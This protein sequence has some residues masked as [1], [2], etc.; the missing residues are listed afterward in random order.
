MILPTFSEGQILAELVED[1]KQIK[2]HAKKKADAYLYKARKCGRFIRETDYD[3]LLV[4]TS[5][6]NVWDL[7]IEYDQTKRIPWSFRA[8]C[9]VESDKKTKDYYLVRGVNSDN[10]YFV[11]VTSHALKRYKERNF[12]DRFHL[13]L[14]TY[15]C[16]AF[17]HRETAVCMR[18]VDLKFSQLLHNMNDVDDI[19][20]MSY[21]V[22]TDRGV[23]FAS[24]TSL[25]NYVFK[26]YISTMMGL[27]EV[28]KFNNKKNTKWKKEGEL[29]HNMIIVHQYYNKFL[30]D[31]KV[32]DDM[33]YSVIGR[34]QEMVLNK[35]IDVYLLNN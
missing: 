30:Y 32:L 10:P 6:N 33:L 35:N 7:E 3:S 18:F 17:E 11:K 14:S 25:G 27:A 5:S 16:M 9:I 15:A 4:K 31:K 21:I 8:C 34:D 24:R 23:Y 28:L 1:Y 19:S 22:L 26:T 29:L 12:F 20:D 13:E 2:R